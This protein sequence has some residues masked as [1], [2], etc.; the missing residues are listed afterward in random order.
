M[1]ITKYGHCCL[2]IE[3]G[4]LR[5]LTDPGSYSTLPDGLNSID[6]I[7]LTHEH[8]DHLHIDSLKTVL[9]N[10]PQAK[11]LTNKTVGSLLEKEGI[12]Y[13][14]IEDGQSVTEKGIL[15]EGFGKEHAVIYPT[16]PV[17]ENI[18]LF[19]A[20]KLF[21]PGDA[22]TEPHHPVEI[23]A[24]P[25]AGPWLKLSEAIDYALKLKPRVCFP[26]HD[27]ILKNPGLCHRLPSTVLEPQDIKFIAM[28]EGK[29]Y[30]V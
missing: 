24:L 8:Q 9:K 25:V 11:V 20:G 18:G 5:I 23:L 2:L 3:E 6:L 10:N 12:A 30:V 4:G 14:L 21:Y 27:G 16:I 7:L 1:T 29:T 22:L 19:I 17:T 28:E 26:V 15:V 13:Q